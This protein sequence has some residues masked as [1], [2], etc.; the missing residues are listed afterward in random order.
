MVGPIDMFSL[1]LY[2]FGCHVREGGEE[3]KEMERKMR[4][5]KLLYVCLDVEEKGK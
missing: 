4:K 1:A 3:I 5:K 2:M